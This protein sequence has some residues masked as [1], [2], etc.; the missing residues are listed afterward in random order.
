M[1]YCLKVNLWVQ[2]AIY[3]A[4]LTKCTFKQSLINTDKTRT[5]INTDNSRILLV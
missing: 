2:F 4:Q 1:L 5:L 3:D